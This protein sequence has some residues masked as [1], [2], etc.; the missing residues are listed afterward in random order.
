VCGDFET[1]SLYFSFF[2]PKS[3]HT[4]IACKK[5]PNAYKDIIG[6]NIRSLMQGMIH[7]A[8]GEKAESWDELKP[9]GRVYV[10]H[11]T[12]MLPDKIN[13]LTEEYKKDGL[14][15]LFRGHDYEIMRNSPLYDG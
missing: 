1:K 10:Y 6:G 14:S 9:S 5:L 3:D 2:L 8:P 7:Q 11:E 15:P 13:E 12:K 4:F